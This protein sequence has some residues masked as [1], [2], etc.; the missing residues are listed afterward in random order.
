M[1]NVGSQ[2]MGR[3]IRMGSI[4]PHNVLSIRHIGPYTE[5]SPTWEKL[6]SIASAHGI[7]LASAQTIGIVYDDPTIT[8]PERIRYDAC[9]SVPESHLY[10]LRMSTEQGNPLA[11]RLQTIR[12]GSAVVAVH[13]GDYGELIQ[14][15]TDVFQQVAFESRAEKL[16]APLPPYYE[17]YR[18]HP[19]VTPSAELI[20]EI[21]FPTRVQAVAS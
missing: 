3:E 13:Q 17:F 4:D 11:A 1:A 21:H 2:G 16:P 5:V 12:G 19:Y 8:A 7:A 10:N 15:Y 18:N 9:I 20:T 6:I 14:A